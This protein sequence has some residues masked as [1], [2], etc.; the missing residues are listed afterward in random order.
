MEIVTEL[1]LIAQF[2]VGTVFLISAAGKLRDPR[3]FTRGIEDYEI[4][5][6]RMALSASLLI[7]V[8]E[9]WLATAHLT[10]W[11]LSWALPAG[12]ALLA[13]FAAAVAV[14]LRRGRTLPC[15]CF[16]TLGRESISGRTLGRLLLLFS[17]EVLLLANSTLVANTRIVHEQIQPSERLELAFS[18]AIFLLVASSWL[19]SM[20][21]LADLLRKPKAQT[22]HASVSDSRRPG[23][24]P[25]EHLLNTNT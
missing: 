22:A 5:P 9:I 11:W 15:Y 19:L 14:N 6:E 1:L 7:I 4:L 3:S 18:W 17:T 16:G 8:V 10:G 12:S 21:E 23:H 13:C 25:G 2:A 24:L 20:P